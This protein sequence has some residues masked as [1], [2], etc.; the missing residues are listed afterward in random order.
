MD[1]R[2]AI[3]YGKITAF[4]SGDDIVARMRKYKTGVEK[5]GVKM[6]FWGHPFGVEEDIVVVLDFGGDMKKYMALSMDETLTAPYSG[7]RTNFVLER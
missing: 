2:Y 3:T 1:F 4:T 6:V 5:H 7:S